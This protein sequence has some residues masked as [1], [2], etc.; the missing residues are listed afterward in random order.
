MQI[1]LL[2]PGNKDDEGMVLSSRNSKYQRIP[3]SHKRIETI[4]YDAFPIHNKPKQKNWDFPGG[5][6]V[7][8][9]VLQMQGVEV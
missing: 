9:S 4:A 1:V 5:P 2:A 3:D 7:K 8:D 6:M